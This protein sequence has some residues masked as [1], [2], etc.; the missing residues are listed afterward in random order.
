M[1]RKVTPQKV[2]RMFFIVCGVLLFQFVNAQDSLGRYQLGERNYNAMPKLIKLAVAAQDVK[3]AG[4]I[5][6]EYLH[7]Y[8]S[9]AP[10]SIFFLADNLSLIQKYEKVSSYGSFKRYFDAQERVDIVLQRPGAAKSKIESIISREEITPRLYLNSDTKQPID[11]TPAWKK[12]SRVIKNKYGRIYSDKTILFAQVNWYLSRKE[13]DNAVKFMVKKIDQYGLD[14]ANLI[15][16][17]FTSNMFGWL[18]FYHTGDKKILR[19]AVRWEK[20]IISNPA[21]YHQGV[22]DVYAA[23]LYK[24][25]EIKKA[26][27]W[28]QKAVDLEEEAAA[29]RKGDKTPMPTFRDNLERMKRG[30]PAA[31]LVNV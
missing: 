26:I 29:K 5:A 11:S 14:T 30:E 2:I 7:Q 19:K 28:Q 15:S 31:N 12:I 18:I 22:L 10:D 9:A 6:L 16:A 20:G 27:E 21:N 17:T 13:W 23:L 1:K 3:L 25:G 4:D 8:L 24:L